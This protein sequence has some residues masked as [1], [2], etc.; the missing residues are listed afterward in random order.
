VERVRRER[1]NVALS[2]HGNSMR[3]ISG[4]SSTWTSRGCSRT[5]TPWVK[6]TRYTLSVTRSA[7]CRNLIT[8]VNRTGAALVTPNTMPALV[9][10]PF[11]R[12]SF[13]CRSG[14]K[15]RIVRGPAFE[16]HLA[17]SRRP[18]CVPTARIGSRVRASSV[19][20]A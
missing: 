14:G 5:R 8:V 15:R 2:A 13:L 9:D 3:A 20:S 1:I 7:R 19:S 16:G 10:G 6:I 12:S 11:R 4:T 18:R 17:R